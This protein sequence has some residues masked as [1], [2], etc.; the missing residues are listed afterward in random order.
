MEKGDAYTRTYPGEKRES[1]EGVNT[2]GGPGEPM[3][4]SISLRALVDF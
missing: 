4:F 3:P 1:T 2:R